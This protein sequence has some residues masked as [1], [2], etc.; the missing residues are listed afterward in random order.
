MERILHHWC[1]RYLQNAHLKVTGRHVRCK[2]GNIS[3]TAPDGVVA[4][5]DY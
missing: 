5:T 2:L 1:K 3:E 4:T